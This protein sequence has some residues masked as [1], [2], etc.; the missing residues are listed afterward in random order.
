M[1]RKGSGRHS[2]A[3]RAR[4]A[5]ILRD[6]TRSPPKRAAPRSLRTSSQK[7]RQ[8]A[9]AAK[10]V[11]GATT[12]TQ[13]HWNSSPNSRVASGRDRSGAAIRRIQEVT[14]LLHEL[15][16]AAVVVVNL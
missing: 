12:G 13:L 2:P 6:G 3:R 15:R 4:A 8:H 14:T 9:L 11:Q 10:L 16:Y 1:I 5:R 7:L